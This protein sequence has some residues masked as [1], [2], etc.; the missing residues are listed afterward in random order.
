MHVAFK[1]RCYFHLLMAFQDGQLPSAG[2]RLRDGRRGVQ[3]L[4]ISIRWARRDRLLMLK[5]K[6]C[7]KKHYL[8]WR[9]WE[10]TAAV[11]VEE[12]GKSRRDERK[13]SK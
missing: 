2:T 13:D 8:S 5:R 11:F 10:E 3:M 4:L 9:A 7:S 12:K 6:I 1:G